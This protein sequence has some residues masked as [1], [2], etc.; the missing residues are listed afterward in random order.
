LF[1]TL[2]LWLLAVRPLAA[3][4]APRHSMHSTRCPDPIHCILCQGTRS[5]TRSAHGSRMSWVGLT[6]KIKKTSPQVIRFRSAHA[7]VSLSRTY[8]CVWCADSDLAAT[9]AAAALPHA[10]HQPKSK[11]GCLKALEDQE[12]LKHKLRNDVRKMTER[13]AQLQADIGPLEKQSSVL[14]AAVSELNR[15]AG[16]SQLAEGF[17]KQEIYSWYTAL[18]SALSAQTGLKLQLV[19][20]GTVSDK[21]KKVAITL[22][23]FYTGAPTGDPDSSAMS[24]DIPEEAPSTEPVLCHGTHTLNVTYDVTGTELASVTMTP[25]DV[26]IEDLVAHGLRT[27]NLRFLVRELRSRIGNYYCRRDEISTIGNSQPGGIGS[28]AVREEAH[29]LVSMALPNGLRCIL[30]VGHD[31]P[32]EHAVLRIMRWEDDGGRTPLAV[33]EQLK[34]SPPGASDASLTEFC[35]ALKQR[36]QELQLM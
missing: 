19:S 27:N 8:I 28:I 24:L 20:D 34:G 10:W 36:A 18:A 21:R 32:R 13:K 35:E 12:E 1:R 7:R 16:G 30:S 22:Q 3:L 29:G 9:A 33:M 11:E 14:S 4:A 17:K 23:S 31:Y 6:N 25:A 15:H 2:R 5:W 26:P